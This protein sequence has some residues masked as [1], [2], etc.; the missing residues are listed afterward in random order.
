MTKD[1]TTDDD[2]RLAHA[3]ACLNQAL[4]LFRQGRFKSALQGMRYALALEPKIHRAVTQSMAMVLGAIAP[5]VYETELER[6][7]LLCLANPD[8]DHQVLSD[9]IASQLLYKYQIDQVPSSETS[10]YELIDRIAQDELWLRF[11]ATVINVSADMEVLLCAV[12]RT[13]LFQLKDSA[14]LTNGQQAIIAALGLQCYANEYIFLVSRSEAD[15]VEALF[16]KFQ[17]APE[18]NSQER[19]ITLALLLSMYHPLLNLGAED[20]SSMLLK[21]LGRP[22]QVYELVK[23][24]VTEPLLQ[25]SLASTIPSMT[26]V[27]DAISRHVKAQYEQNPYPRWRTAP[28]LA[29]ASI[30]Q[31]LHR[32]PGFRPQSFLVGAINVLVAGCGTGYEPISLARMDPELKITAVDLSTNSLSYGLHKAKTLEVPGIQFIQGDILELHR[33]NLCFDL[34]VCTGVLHH[35]DD[36][37]AGWRSLCAVTRPGGVMRMSLYSNYGR[38][39]VVCARDAISAQGLRALPE[40]IKKFRADLFKASPNSELGQMTQSR[41]FYSLSGCRDLLFHVQEHRFNL[42]QIA[43]MLEQLKLELIG[44]DIPG[45]AVQESFSK[46]FPGEDALCDLYKWDEFEKRFPDTF[47]GMYQLW[48]QKN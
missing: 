31:L 17:R 48:L 32:L 30:S 42:P 40:D 14:G 26:S 3:N 19:H 2:A 16:D 28:P 10:F 5:D 37:L 9:L 22:C 21:E 45:P 18:E 15:I 13:L 47:T 23:L 4:M 11:L 44:I 33:L 20:L 27:E 46:M 35:L 39:R 24:S 25:K 8:I 7:L 6:D 43:T 34:V 36:P 38:R 12:R 29:N 41:D 1:G